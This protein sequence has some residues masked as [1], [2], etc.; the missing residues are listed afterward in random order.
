MRMPAAH[1]FTSKMRKRPRWSISFL[2]K[3]TFDVKTP[4]LFRCEELVDGAINFLGLFGEREVACV[5]E[6]E[7]LR[8]GNQL[9][10]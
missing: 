7:I 9:I 3:D 8:A 5:V 1:L 2:T 4:L 6:S 10:V